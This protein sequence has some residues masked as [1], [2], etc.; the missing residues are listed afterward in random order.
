MPVNL[1]NG[2]YILI[3]VNLY[4]YGKH[5]SRISTLF[6]CEEVISLVV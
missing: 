2:G 5:L 3:A 6:L 4:R 1:E